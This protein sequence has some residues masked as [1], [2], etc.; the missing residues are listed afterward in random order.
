MD[1]MVLQACLFFLLDTENKLNDTFEPKVVLNMLHF[2]K[3]EEES[4]NCILGC[5]AT[6]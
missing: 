6:Y 3:V 1:M 2:L 5:D 4:N